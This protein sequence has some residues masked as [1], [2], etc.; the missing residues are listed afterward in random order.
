MSGMGEGGCGWVWVT[1]GGL[2]QAKSNYNASIKYVVQLKNLPATIYVR[3]F[4]IDS[5]KIYF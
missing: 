2:Y 3:N 4:C 1:V 5:F